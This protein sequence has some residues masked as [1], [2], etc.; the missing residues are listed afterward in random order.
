[1][2]PSLVVWTSALIV[3]ALLVPGGRGR[4][5]QSTV[6]DQDLIAAEQLPGVHYTVK[7][8]PIPSLA[9]LPP[10]PSPALNPNPEVPVTPYVAA[11]A[12]ANLSSSHLQLPMPPPFALLP[13]TFPPRQGL[14]PMPVVAVAN[15]PAN[16]AARMSQEKGM[17]F[18]GKN[19]NKKLPAMR[20]KL[21][22]MIRGIY[23]T[24]DAAAASSAGG[25]GSVSSSSALQQTEQRNL[26]ALADAEK[27]IKDLKLHRRV[28]HLEVDTAR[29]GHN[30]LIRLDDGSEACAK[31]RRNY[32]QIQGEIFAYFL[33]DLLQMRHHLPP[34]VLV[35]AV[36]SRLFEPVT[37]AIQRS[38]TWD[39]TKPFVI[40]KY[41]TNLKPLLIPAILHPLIKSIVMKSQ[42]ALQQ[43]G[44]TAAPEANGQPI[45]STIAEAVDPVISPRSQQL[46][47]LS[48]AELRELLQWSD[49]VIFDYLLGNLD[50]LT[51]TA[52]NLQWHQGMLTMPVHNAFQTTSGSSDSS[53]DGNFIF[54]D[55]ESG[56][57]HGYRLLDQYD[58]YLQPLLRSFCVFNKSTVNAVKKLHQS[59]SAGTQLMKMLATEYPKLIIHLPGI[60][61]KTSRILQKRLRYVYSHIR[62]CEENYFLP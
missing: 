38:P 60:G 26:K 16:S 14:P 3:F 12:V 51:N 30:Y 54:V 34:T 18:L 49:M 29:C 45:N 24:L 25:A 23:W 41:L 10:S 17:L 11:A 50:R 40:T 57:F 1:M 15:D 37:Q 31:Q 62:F 21:A 33:A 27:W 56:L 6:G 7:I 36:P 4:S 59:R 8:H 44:N 43:T 53:A 28:V 19:G 52:V 58:R 42:E 32:D 2:E 47:Q 22:G 46:A 20:S 48:R 61:P 55:N 39:P 35:K 9:P 13:P 5:I